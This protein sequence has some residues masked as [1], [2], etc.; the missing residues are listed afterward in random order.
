MKFV[1]TSLLAVLAF[2]AVS[3]QAAV[4]SGAPKPTQ[5]VPAQTA[6]SD[7]QQPSNNGTVQAPA[8][9]T[10]HEDLVLDGARWAGKPTGFVCSSDTAQLV[11]APSDY[12]SIG[13]KFE[14]AV[15]D[16]TL[17]N[18]LVVGTF[19][20]EEGT[21][22]RYSARILADNAASTL[23]LIESRAYA[24]EGEASCAEGK[25]LV[26]AA[27]ESD[28]YIFKE[29]G[30]MLTVLAPNANAAEVCGE[31]AETIGIQFTLAGKIN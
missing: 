30:H 28:R 13:L 6:P 9:E 31:G 11:S 29:R 20:P 16:Y 25:A 10:P 12:A 4:V 3:A 1:N 19:S 21:T 17:D 22:C 15:T 5:N 8:D 14:S 7:E 23:K 26:D 18:G 24:S 27:F 2:A